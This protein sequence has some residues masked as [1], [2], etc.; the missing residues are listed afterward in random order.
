MD[1]QIEHLRLDRNRRGGADELAP[2]GIKALIGKEK[3]HVGC[4]PLRRRLKRKSIRSQAQI[5]RPGKHFA[6][7]PSM[8]PPRSVRRDSAGGRSRAPSAAAARL[9]GS[10]LGKKMTKDNIIHAVQVAAT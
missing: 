4:S 8:S 5:K 9:I 3:L 6:C 1:E 10:K 7:I 2:V